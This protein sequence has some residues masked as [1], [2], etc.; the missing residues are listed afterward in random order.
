VIKQIAPK[1][2]SREF[3]DREFNS[4][5]QFLA[6][7]AVSA[8]GLLG[9]SPAFP[10]PGRMA[11]GEYFLLGDGTRGNETLSGDRPY[12]ARPGRVIIWRY[13]QRVSGTVNL[14]FL[15]HSFAAHPAMPH[16]VVTFEK[17]GKHMAEVDLLMQSVVR[18]TRAPQGRRF[19]GH[20]AHAG[21]YIY[22]TQMD[23]ERGRGLVAVLDGADHS[24]LHEYETQGAFPHDCQ[25]Q[26]DG[27][28]LLLV[29][30]RS[31]AGVN[32]TP[33]NRSS[34]VWL[35]MRR[36]KCLKQQYIGGGTYGYAHFVCTADEYIVLSG[37]HNLANGRSAPLLAIIRPDGSELILDVAAAA[38]ETLRGEVLSL[39]IDE[40]ASELFATL[41]NANR[42]QVWNYRKAELLRQFKIAEPRGLAYSEEFKSVLVSSAQEKNIY[43]V[44][45]QGVNERLPSFD[46]GVAG[47]GSHLHRL[48]F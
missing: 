29:N 41:P 35:D 34:L 26:G 32:A 21:Q 39:H 3:S 11:E 1:S 4:R 20:G 6:W 31:H 24:V 47:N 44:G 18:V 30:S 23:D 45:R 5:R 14:P 42:L 27:T 15:P 22:A 2:E 46:P 33:D 38:A 9:A 36:G 19:F 43:L 40:H 25:L 10:A 13:K 7:S 28:T 8:A 48:E 17:W 12:I 37:S 16:R